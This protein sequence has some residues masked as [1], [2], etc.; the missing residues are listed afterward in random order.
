MSKKIEISEEFVKKILE[1]GGADERKKLIEDLLIDRDFNLKM[2]KNL[3]KK[4]EEK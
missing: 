3:E 4:L 1:N 2:I